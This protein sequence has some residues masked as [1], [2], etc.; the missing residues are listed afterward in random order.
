[1]EIKINKEIS[2]YKESM[3]FGLSMRQT[4]CA[5]IACAVAVGLYF[6]LE[7]QIGAELVSWVCILGAAPFAVLGFVKYN[8]MYAEKFIWA[9]FKSKVLMPKKYVFRGE[10]F[11]YEASKSYIE[12]KKKEGMK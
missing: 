7:P 6:W 3:F 10:N 11:Y 1:M 5:V 2:E 4:V 8:G 12:K 9:W